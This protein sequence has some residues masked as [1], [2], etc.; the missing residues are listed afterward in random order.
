MD[1]KQKYNLRMKKYRD[2]NKLMNS[3]HCHNYKRKNKGFNYISVIEYLEYRK[4]VK[5]NIINKL[6][7]SKKSNFVRWEEY[8][9]KNNLIF[10]DRVLKGNFTPK[11]K[12]LI[13][14]E[15]A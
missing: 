9:Q 11:I 8:K 15:F 6:K 4:F 13:K 1:D 5:T 10:E 7:S 2:Q 3:Y 14:E 12:K